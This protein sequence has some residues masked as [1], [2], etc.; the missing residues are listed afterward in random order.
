MSH[1]EHI[2]VRAQGVDLALVGDLWHPNV[3][4]PSRG[5]VL[6][7]HGGGQT[8]QSWKESAQSFATHGWTA[9]AMD[10]RGHGGSGWAPHR[11]YSVD[12][13]IA[14]IKA[15]ASQL[16]TPLVLIG[17]SMGGLCSL[18]AQGEDPDLASALVLVDVVPQ[19]ELDGLERIAAFMMSA[20]DG[21]ET[22]QEASDAVHAYN[23]RRPKP[24]SLDGL[25]KNL[26]NHPSGRWYWHWDPAFLDSVDEMTSSV[27]LDRL[28]RA[29]RNIDVPT[30]LVWGTQSDVVSPT[31]VEEFLTLVP[32]ARVEKAH[33]G[34]MIA[35]DN[36]D[37]FARRIMAF[38]D[39]VV[40]PEA[41]H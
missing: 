26:V 11:D 27:H 21:F 18:I 20:P 40:R 25:K 16:D 23:P 41:A 6:L 9:L 3:D 36:N 10:A 2:T 35:G 30:M 12:S 29:S 8:R 38:L 24:P 14:D 5:S 37:V 31:G 33:A 19:L 28:N 13:M 15:A 7:L 22:L 39:E 1:S 17:A 32:H 4:T 34:H